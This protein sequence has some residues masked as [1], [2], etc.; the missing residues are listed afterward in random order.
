MAFP[1]PLP[2]RNK[3]AMAYQPVDT[4]SDG[5]PKAIYLYTTPL[6]NQRRFLK[7]PI[8]I[9]AHWAICIDGHC[10]ELTRNGDRNKNKKEPKYIMKA[11][12]EQEWISKKKDEQRGLEKQLAGYTLFSTKRVHYVGEYRITLPGSK[13]FM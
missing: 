10:Y 6:N 7:K 9:F 12:D 4:S 11:L 5:H 2:P 8:D 1:P 3:S 13:P